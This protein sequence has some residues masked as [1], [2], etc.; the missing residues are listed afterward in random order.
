MTGAPEW[1]YRTFNDVSLTAR[2]EQRN[3]KKTRKPPLT[4]WYKGIVYHAGPR[5]EDDE[6]LKQEYNQMI[7][8]MNNQKEKQSPFNPNRRKTRSDKGQKRKK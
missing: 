5:E 8:E 7:L 1:R 2:G 6:E 4:I 3:D